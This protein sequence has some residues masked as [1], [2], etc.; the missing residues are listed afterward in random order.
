[1]RKTTYDLLKRYFRI[2]KMSSCSVC[3]GWQGSGSYNKH[4]FI[5]PSIHQGIFGRCR[6]VTFQYCRQNNKRT[7]VFQSYLPRTVAQQR[8]LML[9]LNWEAR[10]HSLCILFKMI[11]IIPEPAPAAKR[12]ITPAQVATYSLRRSKSMSWNFVDVWG[13]LRN[14]WGS[15][16]EWDSLKEEENLKF[17]K[18]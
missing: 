4:I 15:F 5:H 10:F 11:Q 12:H 8:T 3:G 16:L 18:Q 9:K 1:M 7:A 13:S 14:H 6:I 2:I 17:S